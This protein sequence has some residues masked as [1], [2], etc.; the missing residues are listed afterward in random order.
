[1]DSLFKNQF[2]PSLRLIDS[3]LLMGITPKTLRKM[4]LQ[5]EVTS[6]P[7][8]IIQLPNTKKLSNHVLKATFN[9]FSLSLNSVP[10]YPKFYSTNY[11]HSNG[12][13]EY[14]HCLMVSEKI[15]AKVLE[16][17]KEIKN[18]PGFLDF[19]ETRQNIT[20]EIEETYYVPVVICIKSSAN[21]VDVFKNILSAVFAQ[22]FCFA[23]HEKAE[24][25]TVSTEFIKNAMFLINDLI[26]PPPSVKISF[27]IGSFSISLPVEYDEKIHFF[28]SNLIVLLDLIDIRNI[29]KAW[30][31]ILCGK[32]MVVVGSNDYTI[33]LVIQALVSLVFP[34]K[35]TQFCLPLTSPEGFSEI[36]LNKPMII[37]MNSSQ[38]AS[39]EI[40]RIDPELNILDIDTNYLHSI[41]ESLLCDCVRCEIGQKLQYLKAFY[42]VNIER[43][44]IYRMNAMAKC[45]KDQDFL[46]KAKFLAEIEDFSNKDAIFVELIRDVFFSVFFSSLADYNKFTIIQPLTNCLEFMTEE[47]LESIQTC[48]VCTLPAFWKTFT[49]SQI[50]KDFIES[51]EKLDN[52]VHKK[53]SLICEKMKNEEFLKS[54]PQPLYE[55]DISEKMTTKGFYSKLLEVISGL[56]SEN[57]QN[58]YVLLT[59]LQLHKDARQMVDLPCEEIRSLNEVVAEVE[60]CR[61]QGTPYKLPNV[62]YGDFCIIKM[63]AGLV[64]PISRGFFRTFSIDS[65]IFRATA[66]DSHDSPE[67]LFVLICYTLKRSRKNWDTKEI[68]ALCKQLEK[69]MPGLLPLYHISEIIEKELKSG[70]NALD[71]LIEDS[72]SMMNIADLIV[73]SQDSMIMKEGLSEIS[74]GKKGSARKKN[75]GGRFSER[76]SSQSPENSLM[77]S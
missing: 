70:K 6:N 36:L 76:K 34:F 11:T 62:F 18:P 44:N 69:A 3:I 54:L 58:K 14:L 43:L 2:R 72:P 64:K 41:D 22:C 1:M 59:A 32:S 12:K 48:E 77:D 50:F 53:F 73:K 38:I 52:Q 40:S 39:E 71:Q 68:L 25:F 15:T 65:N 33:Y 37:G 75:T 51:S 57:A 10:D 46:I 21:Y 9:P 45:L 47:Y 29:I 24:S 67:A 23:S 4:L 30:E 35:I 63:L 27:Q 13:T 56:S 61:F 74:L 7:E 17:S 60:T 20:E 8:V 16:Q 26:I 19:I 55:L 31:Y 66:S 28:E 5:S 42:Y 49:Q